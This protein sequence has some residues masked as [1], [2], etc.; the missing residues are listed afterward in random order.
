MSSA[1]QLA[2]FFDY[3]AHNKRASKHTVVSY[4]NDLRHFFSFLKNHLGESVT[5]KNLKTL[6]ARDFRA[7]LASRA[8]QFESSS[9]ARALSSV[10]SYFRYLE[11]QN[12]LANSAIFHLKSPKIKK[13]LPKAV[14]E[15]KAQETLAAIARDDWMGK[16]DLA[17]LLL[18]YGCGLRISEALSLSVADAR[19]K[20]ALIITGKGNK[21]RMVPLLPIITEAIDDYLAHRPIAMESDSPLFVGKQ[22]KRLDPAIFQKTL[23]NL[24][25]QLGLPDTATPHAFRHSFATHLLA[26]GSDLRSIQELLG[27]A[28]LSTTQRY[29]QVDSA[30]LLSAYEKAHPRA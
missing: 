23:R 6:E 20:D 5:I 22:G 27:H 11:K 21:Q 2:Q 30:R 18:L 19:N 24:R 9:N 17:L 4:E 28:S 10:K 15:E 25:A 1:P 7:W 16:R 26:A 3:L 12:V 13:A 14:G 29:T 8:G